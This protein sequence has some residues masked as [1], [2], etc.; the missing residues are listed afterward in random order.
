EFLMFTRRFMAFAVLPLALL[1]AAPTAP[2]HADDTDPEALVNALN[3]IFGAN[4]GKR[5]AHTHGFC[6]KGSFAPTDAA[7]AYSK[8]PHLSGKG[9]WPVIGRYSMGGGNPLAPNS[10][11]DNVRGIALHFDLGDGNQTDM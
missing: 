4:A 3:A 6:V 2:A 10:Q 5:A 1:I 9:P 7:A 11:K 8:A